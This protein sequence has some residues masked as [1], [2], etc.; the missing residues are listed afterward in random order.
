M[1]PSVPQEK[2]SCCSNRIKLGCQT[3]K[4]WTLTYSLKW[5]LLVE[6]KP[7]EATILVLGSPLEIALSVTANRRLE[8]QQNA[9]L[10][11]TWGGRGKPP[12]HHLTAGSGKYGALDSFFYP[13]HRFSSNSSILTATH[14]DILRLVQSSRGIT[15]PSEFDMVFCTQW[16][17]MHALQR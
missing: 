14:S 8:P 5:Q 10:H 9:A 16:V 12:S 1:L 13:M 3:V 15:S 11:N 2:T 4:Y 6:E 7:G 17:Q